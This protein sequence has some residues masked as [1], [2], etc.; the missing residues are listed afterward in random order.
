MKIYEWEYEWNSEVD[1][2]GKSVSANE[3]ERDGCWTQECIM[4]WVSVN[5]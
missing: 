1:L 3:L 5:Y 2:S 4:D